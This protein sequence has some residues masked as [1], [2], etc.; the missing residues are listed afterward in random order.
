MNGFILL[1][2]L[3]FSVNF[4]DVGCCFLMK[5]N[6]PEKLKS[7][8]C[9]MFLVQVVELCGYLKFINQNK[10]KDF[11]RENTAFLLGHLVVRCVAVIAIRLTPSKIGWKMKKTTKESAQICL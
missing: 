4:A 11:G 3:E 9:M 10:V 8:I 5:S 2:S 1:L 6:L 7:Q